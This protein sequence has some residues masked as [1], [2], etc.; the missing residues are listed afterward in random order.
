MC[1]TLAIFIA[2]V[3]RCIY[4]VCILWGLTHTHKVKRQFVFLSPL[5]LNS[6]PRDDLVDLGLIS[7]IYKQIVGK[8]L[9]GVTNE[10]KTGKSLLESE[11]R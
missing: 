6:G 9:C 2:A 3:T 7:R 1:I 8:T 5:S 10:Q 11:K 4:S